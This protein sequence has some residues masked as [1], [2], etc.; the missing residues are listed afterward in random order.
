MFSNVPGPSEALYLSG[1]E[2]L[3]AVPLFSHINC[4][5]MC[6]SFRD[7]V[8]V[9]A[10]IDP[11]RVKHADALRECFVEEVNAAIKEFGIKQPLLKIQTEFW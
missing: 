6:L 4:Q 8:S 10:C 7:K 2:L 11:V 5:T 3:R 1:H 9:S